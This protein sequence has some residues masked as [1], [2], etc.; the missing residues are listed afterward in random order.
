MEASRA[1]ELAGDARRITE[2]VTGHA[3]AAI[4]LM[5]AGS[6]QATAKA[7]CG[8]VHEMT[9]EFARLTILLHGAR[10]TYSSGMS[11][12]DLRVWAN[13]IVMELQA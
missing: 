8:Q 6:V 4:N 2:T 5:A 11:E 13:S 12:A 1:F 9:A 3:H 10:L 7:R